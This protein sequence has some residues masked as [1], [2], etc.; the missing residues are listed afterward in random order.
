MGGARHEP[1][2]TAKRAGRLSE[3]YCHTVDYS[4]VH[5]QHVNSCVSKRRTTGLSTNAYYP[6]HSDTGH[7]ATLP[8]DIRE[9]I[10]LI[11][12]TEGKHDN[13]KR[14]F[15]KHQVVYENLFE[16]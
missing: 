7:W 16:L 2:D 4:V 15:V 12:R 6:A 14:N 5:H 1:G 9:F 8:D 11:Q 10:S 13:G 3:T